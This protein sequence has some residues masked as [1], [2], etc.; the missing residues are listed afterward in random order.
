M[1]CIAMFQAMFEKGRDAKDGTFLRLR[2]PHIA[3][4]QSAKPPDSSVTSSK[5]H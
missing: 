2:F 4:S 5:L 1:P 3:V